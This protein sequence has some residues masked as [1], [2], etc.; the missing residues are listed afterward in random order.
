MAEASCT[1]PSIHTPA[2]MRVKCLFTQGCRGMEGT[3]GLILNSQKERKGRKGQI[4]RCYLFKDASL[5]SQALTDSHL[6]S[7]DHFRGQ[8]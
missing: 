3:M 7:W 5:G 8:P 6:V 4:L 1:L 2:P